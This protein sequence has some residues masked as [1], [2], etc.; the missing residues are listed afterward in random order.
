MI[1]LELV[2]LALGLS[3]DAF[4]V[5]I[6]TG[7]AMEK[8]DIKKAMIVGLYFG[9]FQAGM[10]LVGYFAASLFAGRISAYDHWVAFALLSILG[11]KMIIDCF[12]KKGCPDRKCPAGI[13][14]DR[15][16][17]GGIKPCDQEQSLKPA[18]MLPLA[19]AT[20]I[21]ALAV[22]VSFALLHVSIVLAIAIIGIATFAISMAGVRIGNAFG[23]KFKSK[24]HF[25]GGIT[26]VLIGVRTL[27]E[28]L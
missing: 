4:A 22:G 26:L 15:S 23:V 1:V 8:A 17:P 12:K 16:C 28:H 13:C 18:I 5:A 3:M 9:V 20:S 27:H 24:A 7:L 11:V 25:A 10:P 21:D 14:N 19:V 2:I 6:C